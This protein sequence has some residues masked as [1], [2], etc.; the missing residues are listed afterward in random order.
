M[1]C[2]INSMIIIKIN[3][4]HGFI[5]VEIPLNFESFYYFVNTSNYKLKKYP[6]IIVFFFNS[7]QG[8]RMAT[9]SRK[10]EHK[11][12]SNQVDWFPEE[13]SEKLLDS[14]GAGPV[15]VANIKFP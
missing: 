15:R 3:T 6:N 8:P 10:K 14:D 2:D 7:K 12:P 11:L 9:T 1:I 5:Q 13:D 4:F